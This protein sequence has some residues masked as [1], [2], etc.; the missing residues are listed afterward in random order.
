[1]TRV[2]AGPNATQL[3]ADFGAE[4]WKVEAL[5]GDEART[6][7]ASSFS[8]INRGKQSIAINISDPKGQRL[9]RELAKRADVFVENSRWQSPNYS[10]S[11]LIPRFH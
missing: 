4:V 6:W 9:V 10:V 8:Q 3:M 5:Y 7:G 1:M 2:L 11:T